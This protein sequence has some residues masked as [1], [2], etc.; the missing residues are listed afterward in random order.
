[1]LVFYNH[2]SRDP[3]PTPPTPLPGVTPLRILSKPQA[4]YTDQARANNIQGTV[5]VVV[6]CGANGRIEHVL[7]LKRLDPGLDRQAVEAAKKIRFE[8]KMKDGKPVPTVVTIDYSF[9]IY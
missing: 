1:M 6:L 5:R 8:P 7:L 4:S 3:T 9:S 2:F